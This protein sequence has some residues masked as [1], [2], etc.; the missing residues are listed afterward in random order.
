M[1]GCWP[2]WSSATPLARLP[3]ETWLAWRRTGPEA[4]GG[5]LE[6]SRQYG[7]ESFVCRL[8]AG[9]GA[10]SWT[11]GPSPASATLSATWASPTPTCGTRYS[12]TSGGALP[13]RWRPTRTRLRTSCWA[14]DPTGRGR[15]GR[16]LRI[17]GWPQPRSAPAGGR[18]DRRR[19]DA[20]EI[21]EE[22]WH[23]Q[24]L[25]DLV[26]PA[27][28]AATTPQGG[29]GHSGDAGSWE[30][31]RRLALDAV[32]RDGTDVGRANGCSR[33]LVRVWAAEDGQAWSR[34][35]WRSPRLAELARHRPPQWA[36]CIQATPSPSPR[37]CDTRSCAPAWT[38]GVPRRRRA[39]L[40]RHLLGE[41]VAAGGRLIVGTYTEER[42]DDRLERE[43]TS[44]GHRVVGRSSRPHQHPRLAYKACWIDA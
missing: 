15:P 27:Y 38:K 37:L 12:T 10:L 9:N 18:R 8:H 1:S 36:D 26:E 23:R 24:V 11:S 2:T 34:R 21:D 17:Y 28:L 31:A 14:D 43:L 39:D 22:G 6:Y 32:D 16:W 25:L 3:P 40:V 30:H 13:G 5:P 44:W 19:L 35:A 29:S 41:V 7:D 20:G 4:L 33:S 42:D